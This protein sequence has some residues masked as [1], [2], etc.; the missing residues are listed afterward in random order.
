MLSARY[1]H[2]IGKDKGT[3]A[4]TTIPIVHEPL[5]IA[6]SEA[7]GITVA[8]S[9]SCGY[10]RGAFKPATAGGMDVRFMPPAFAGFS[11]LG[12]V[13]PQLALWATDMPP[14]SP[15]GELIH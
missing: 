3:I 8:H 11:M 4:S 1:R 5:L 13:E 6:A 14:A 10:N 7:G 9:A 15:A 2:V 12:F